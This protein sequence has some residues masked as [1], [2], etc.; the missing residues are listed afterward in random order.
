MGRGDTDEEDRRP[1][2][3]YIDE[4]QNYASD[5]FLEII[6]E[7]RKYKLSLTLA[8]QNL[9][10]VESQGLKRSLTNCG[11]QIY[12]RVSRPDA[13]LLAKE[14][15]VGVFGEAPPWEELIQRLQNWPEG[16]FTAKSK[17]SGGLCELHA[18]SIISAFELSGMESKEEFKA[19]VEK[20]NMGRSYLRERDDV[21]KEYRARRES[22]YEEEPE[23][24][25]VKK[26]QPAPRT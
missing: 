23:S 19:M 16:F 24:F 15:Y 22:L 9:G 4:F 17:V 12:F 1:F 21:E 25:S 10:Q 2:Y 5:S 8:H 18:P 11:T 26:K 14:A 20:T 13:E 6:D 7:S 3:L